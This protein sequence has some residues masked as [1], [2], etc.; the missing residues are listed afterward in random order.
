RL[1]LLALALQHRERGAGGGGRAVQRVLQFA[2]QP[3]QRLVVVA[4]RVVQQLQGVEQALQHAR[5]EYRR[6]DQF[7]QARAQG[8]QVAGE[9]AAVHRRDV[10]RRQRLQGLRVVPVVEV[11]AVA[12]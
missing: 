10:Q 4:E 11:A 5:P 12:R 8:Q 6:I 1:R 3:V 7:E 2:L 9:V